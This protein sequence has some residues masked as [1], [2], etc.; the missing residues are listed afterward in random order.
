M[1]GNDDPSTG[2]QPTQAAT[3]PDTR[4]RKT[5]RSE[6]GKLAQRAYRKRHAS[7]FRKLQEDNKALCRIIS[8][9]DSTLQAQGLLSAEVAA[10][11]AEATGLC[12]DDDTSD[13]ATTEQQQ[14]GAGHEPD[15]CRMDS[16]AR[17]SGEAIRQDAAVEAAAD[18]RHVVVATQGDPAASSAPTPPPPPG[19]GAGT[20]LHEAAPS[21]VPNKTTILASSSHVDDCGGG[22][23]A[24]PLGNLSCNPAVIQYYLNEGMPTFAGC[25]FWACLTQT[26]EVFEGSERGGARQEEE[27]VAGATAAPAAAAAPETRRRDPQQGTEAAGG[28]GLLDLMVE[29]PNYGRCLRRVF[30]RSEHVGDPGF[31][32]RLERCRAHY[33]RYGRVVARR[34][35]SPLLYWAS[36]PADDPWPVTLGGGGGSGSSDGEGERG[37]PH[38]GSP[39]CRTVDGVV[40]HLEGQIGG[41][42]MRRLDAFMRRAGAVV[43]GADDGTS[44]ARDVEWAKR[45]GGLVLSLAQNCKLVDGALRWD[46]VW[47][48]LMVGGWVDYNRSWIYEEGGGDE[49]DYEAVG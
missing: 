44:S 2:S 28:S 25:I 10:I 48:S 41:E 11:L 45:V 47:L 37:K 17:P 27:A 31:L 46:V 29:P 42:A 15:A 13:G 20:C 22:D 9:L 18:S 35:S 6:R 5:R 23:D 16:R 33:L 30:A 38:A 43:K 40:A 26:V 7:R 32:P 14:Q 24:A 3:G 12:R 4:E 39:W 36:S 49:G 34:G 1:T 21:D 8:R 19:S